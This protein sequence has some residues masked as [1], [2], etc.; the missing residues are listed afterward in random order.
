MEELDK[1]TDLINAILATLISMCSFI[2]GLVN[3]DEPHSALYFG[4]AFVCGVLA[5]NY[6][7]SREK[8]KK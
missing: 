2:Y 5:R 6:F 3:F 7:Q 4:L 1:T 8:E